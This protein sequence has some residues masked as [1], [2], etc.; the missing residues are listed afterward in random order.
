MMLKQSKRRKRGISSLSNLHTRQP[1]IHK[2]LS[3]TKSNG[4]RVS[5]SSSFSSSC[6][7][8]NFFGKIRQG[9]RHSEDSR[10]T[11]KGSMAFEGSLVLPLFL[12]FMASLLYN[13]EIVRL[14]SDVFEALH[15]AQSK[16]CVQAYLEKEDFSEYASG[17]LA[18]RVLLWYGVKEGENGL[19]ITST[20]DDG[21]NVRLSAAYEMKPF[22]QLL[23][24]GDAAFHD[25]IYGHGFVGYIPL[26]GGGTVTDEDFYVY[27]T[28]SGTKYHLSEDCTYLKVNIEMVSVEALETMRSKDG[29]KY[30][31]C[32]QCHPQETGMVYIAAWGN[33]YHGDAG[34]T[35]LR[36]AVYII[37]FSEVGSRTACSKCGA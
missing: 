11:L 22:L 17:L 4:G 5:F 10:S 18:E 8:G 32:T 28:A 37:P 14:Q 27:V 35:A 7:F 29:A 25:S 36:R 24:I 30:Y 26:G 15:Q 31:A 20:W 1:N 12:F 2:S 3:L 21:G 23:P 9:S 34:C 13:M 33:R 19:S 16:A 6:A